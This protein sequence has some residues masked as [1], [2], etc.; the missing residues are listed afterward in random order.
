VLDRSS[1]SKG[2]TRI[3]AKGRTGT[4]KEKMENESRK[5][6]N[7]GNT[8]LECGSLAAAFGRV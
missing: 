5:N 1:D 3:N 8:G 2:K 6:C 4:E 7:A